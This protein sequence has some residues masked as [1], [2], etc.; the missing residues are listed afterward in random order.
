VLEAR[1]GNL[2]VRVD[3]GEPML[4]VGR[5][6]F[7]ALLAGATTAWPLAARAQQLAMPVIGFFRSGW[8]PATSVD[9]LRAFRH[10]L[11][12]SGYARS[13]RSAFAQD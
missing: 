1:R 7:V 3:G 5:R 11:K 8:L 12:E 2:S 13:A 4:D 10:G 6:E 9:R